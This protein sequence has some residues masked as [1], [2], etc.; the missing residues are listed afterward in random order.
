[1]ARAPHKK[2]S[3]DAADVQKFEA[4]GARWWDE[5]GPMKPL[6]Q[7][8]PLRL[9]YIR[10]QA[11]ALLGC[12]DLK[13]L[14]VLDVGCGG[15][16]LTE[17]LA[18]Q[19]AKVTGIDAGAENIAIA[20]THAQKMELKIDYRATTAEDLAA[21]G[22][23]FDIVTALEI[24]EHVTDP[25]VFLTDCAK[26][27]KPGGVMFVSTLNR[28]AKSFALGIVAAEYVLRLLP[29]GTHNWKKFMKPSE[30]AAPMEK[31]GMSIKDITGLVYNPLSGGFTLSRK[32]L[33]VN[34]MMTF[35]KN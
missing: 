26:M 1:M 19:G 5:S 27:V 29:P 24:V 30:I 10:D 6:H 28:T 32:R 14:K 7:M 12:D 22:A 17:P 21:S 4:L 13:D 25:S 31:A 9:R 35:L 33:G 8:N 11:T 16:I 3:V 34:Y 20:K 15:G 18:R 23:Q 2:S